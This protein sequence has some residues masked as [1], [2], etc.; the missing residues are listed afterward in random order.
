MVHNLKKTMTPLQTA[1]LNKLRAQALSVPTMVIETETV[2]HLVDGRVFAL[3]VANFD[4]YP[5]RA[6]EKMICGWIGKR[7]GFT[8]HHI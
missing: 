2:D 6:T 7:G 8:S 4:L 1:K 3:L 5:T